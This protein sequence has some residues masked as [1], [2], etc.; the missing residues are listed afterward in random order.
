M[1]KHRM[2]TLREHFVSKYRQHAAAYIYSWKPAA[3]H[4]SHKHG[5]SA[6]SWMLNGAPFLVHQQQWE[7]QAG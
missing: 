5:H 1:L 4:Q 6:T 7:E 3:G 2:Q